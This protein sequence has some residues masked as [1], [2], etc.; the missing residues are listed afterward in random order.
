MHTRESKQTRAS[1]I[2]E[3][4]GPRI[5]AIGTVEPQGNKHRLAS[6]DI[7]L[8]GKC[9]FG[10]GDLCLQNMESLEKGVVLEKLQ[11]GQVH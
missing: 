7:Q 10:C 6:P 8:Q 2:Y 11:S 1:K 5:E 3:W 4:T 9:A